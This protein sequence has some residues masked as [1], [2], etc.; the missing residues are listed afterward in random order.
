[1]SKAKPLIPGLTETQIL[2][3]CL[4]LLA[5]YGVDADRQ[6][7]GGVI[8]EDKKR[9]R[10][11]YIRFGKPGNT[12]ITGMLP[13]GRKLDI[14]VKRPGKK[15][16]PEQYA[17]IRKTNAMNGVGFWIDDVSVLQKVL[18]IVLAGGRV[19]ESENGELIVTR[20]ACRS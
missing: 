10:L 13:D 18:P 11:R 5:C 16:T 15:P 2:A 7:T 1:M 19:E 8:V 12:D 20:A 6:N 14:E 4:D 17:R 9:D 3:Q